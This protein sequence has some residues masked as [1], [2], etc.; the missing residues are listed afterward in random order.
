MLVKVKMLES[1]VVFSLEEFHNI[2]EL[3]SLAGT[4]ISSIDFE[5]VCNSKLK[6]FSFEN[7]ESTINNELD[8]LE[9]VLLQQPLLPEEVKIISLC[10]TDIKD[11]D[12]HMVSYINDQ[13]RS[14]SIF[15]NCM[16]CWEKHYDSKVLNLQLNMTIEQC[17]YLKEFISI[18]MLPHLDESK[19]Q[20]GNAYGTFV[21][22]LGS[23]LYFCFD[24]DTNG[25]L[26][27][28]DEEGDVLTFNVEA[29]RD[30]LINIRP[31]SEV[32]M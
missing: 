24:H 8:E 30:R 6:P 7:F 14:M 2:V 11:L 5:F 1:R 25:V 22:M 28:I 18:D 29:I 17:K 31:L 27:C 9:V 10:G 3:N 23:G 16:K 4:P 15:Y 19:I 32:H 13:F 20:Q 26:S 21:N 12:H